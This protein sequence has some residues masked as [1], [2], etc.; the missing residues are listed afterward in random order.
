ML[1]INSHFHFRTLTRLFPFGCSPVEKKMIYFSCFILVNNQKN[2]ENQLGIRVID[3]GIGNPR[4]VRD[5]K[6]CKCKSRLEE[7]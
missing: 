6:I 1:F 4:R 5:R 3:S 2:I 7:E